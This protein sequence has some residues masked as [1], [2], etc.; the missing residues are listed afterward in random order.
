MKKQVKAIKNAKALLEHP[1]AKEAYKSLH[2]K[3]KKDRSAETQCHRMLT[4]ETI[5]EMRNIL[6]MDQI[7]VINKDT[8][9]KLFM[10]VVTRW[11]QGKEK[12]SDFLRALE[13]LKQLAPEFVSRSL[14]GEI[15]RMSESDLDK[16]IA[17]IQASIQEKLDKRKN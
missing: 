7:S 5:Q 2:P 11:T 15:E 16:E 12:T 4:P 17:D 14:S 10:L 13:S 9:V 8:L 3:C 1:H 6:Q